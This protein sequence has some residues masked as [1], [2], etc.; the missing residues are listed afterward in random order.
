VLRNSSW[1]T[2]LA[3][4][5][6]PC[7]FSQQQT[8]AQPQVKVNMLNVCTPS[9]DDQ[10]EINSALTRIPK[11]PLFAVDFEVDRGRS[12]L[13]D[14]PDFLQAGKGAQMAIDHSAT[15][16]WVRIRR[17]LSFQALFSTVQYSFSKDAKNMIE[18]LVFRVRDPKDLLQ[19]SIEDNAAAVTSVP[20][21]LKANT[22]ATRIQ[23]ER[24]GKSS[25][26]LARC[27]A[28]EN[29]PAPDQSAYEPI[30]Q[31]A[32]AVI[33]NYRHLLNA[34]HVVPEE[35]ARMSD[36]PAAAKSSPKPAGKSTK[37]AAAKSQ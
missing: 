29:G 12:T 19:V 7:A 35:L 31:H 20:D 28:T 5:F 6:S 9:A 25:I 24:F 8:P 26:V 2:L 17:E 21:M 3:L 10:N 37:P 16:D 30:F 13:E 22:P 11:Q 1:F 15:S 27:F 34:T 33:D 36:N 18:T 14:N 23:L 4:L 32:S